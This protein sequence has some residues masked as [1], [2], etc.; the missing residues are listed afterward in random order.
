MA[1]RSNSPLKTRTKLMKPMMNANHPPR[2][3]HEDQTDET[4]DERKLP[5]KKK[6]RIDE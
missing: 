5:A 4:D 3:S 1:C 6:S 2:R